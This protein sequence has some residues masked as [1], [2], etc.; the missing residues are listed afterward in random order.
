MALEN[1]TEYNCSRCDA[2]F[3]S[4]SELFNHYR[5]F[6]PWNLNHP[7]KRSIDSYRN[8]HF[9]SIKNLEKVIGVCKNASIEIKVPEELRTTQG[10]LRKTKKDLWRLKNKT[11]EV[12][13]NAEA[14]QKNLDSTK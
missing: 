13:K 11:P 3:F 10:L 6:H 9:E 12:L 14:M 5:A 8:R 2:K 7:S 1:E 4:Q